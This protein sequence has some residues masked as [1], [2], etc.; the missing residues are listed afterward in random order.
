LTRRGVREVTGVK[1]EAG[2]KLGR[3][4]QRGEK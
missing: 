4:V 3:E 1:R 2:E